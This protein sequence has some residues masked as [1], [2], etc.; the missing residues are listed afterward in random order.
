LHDLTAAELDG[1]LQSRWTDTRAFAVQRPNIT[2]AQLL[3]VTGA[4]LDPGVR[5]T[6]QG[7]LPP[8]SAN[9]ANVL[10]GSQWPDARRHA[11]EQTTIARDA[12]LLLA[13]ADADEGV[14]RNAQSRLANLSAEEL[15]S[16]VHSRW[17]DARQL[18]V[19]AENATRDQL[20]RLCTDD[21]VD[22]A[23]AAFARLAQTATSD[24][25]GIV[26]INNALW[27]DLARHLLTPSQRVARLLSTNIPRSR[28]VV[29]QEA[30]GYSTT[31][32]YG[33]STWVESSPERAHDEYEDSDATRALALIR[34]GPERL[35]EVLPHLRA[36][37][38]ELSAAI[39]ALLPGGLQP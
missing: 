22:I 2:Q 33:N 26:Q 11:L 35:A 31:D 30:Q 9:E 38:S 3:R 32:S 24:E 4:D 23:R 8:M 29:D 15:V 37:N 18:A 6:A 27:E 13:A 36:I 14:R 20:M 16:L 10:L 28:R 19:T 1:L 25:L 39:A 7:L 12:V 34:G 5:A 21:V 17:P